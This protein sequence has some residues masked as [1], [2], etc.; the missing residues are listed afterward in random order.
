MNFQ[1]QNALYHAWQARSNTGP[2]GKAILVAPRLPV[3]HKAVL[4]ACDGLDGLTD[5]LI[6]DP[7]ACRFDL[8]D[9]LC[10][11]GTQDTVGCLSAAEVDVVRKLYAGPR[12]SATGQRLIVAGPQYGSELGWAGVYV[13]AAADQPI[14]SAMIAL[15]ALRHVVFETNPP[16]VFSLTDVNF[17]QAI[18]ERLRPLHPLYDATN[19]NLSAF[20]AV[21][22]KLILWHGWA[23]PHISP[24]NTIAYHT[25]LVALMGNERTQAFER[26]YLFPGMYHCSGGEG[27]SQVDLLT[28]ILNWVER[29]VAPDAVITGQPERTAANDFGVPIGPVNGAKDGPPKASAERRPAADSDSNAASRPAAIARSRPVYPY[30]SI[31]SYDGRGDPKQAVSF[32]RGA[33]RV[34]FAMPDWAGKDFY[35][36]YLP[37]ER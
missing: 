37:R 33:A 35:R 24:V 17:D 8:A 1:A 13:P 4:N 34:G 36:P 6:S 25:A 31:A 23:D 9:V 30:P 7:L 32:V 28:A 5:G 15:Q 16:A 22:G 20:A 11:A 21:G 10:S 3:L 19:P 29:G 12:D 2:N 18:F 14:F 26:L 27:P